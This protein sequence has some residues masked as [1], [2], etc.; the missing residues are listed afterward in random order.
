MKRVTA[1]A[2]LPAALVVGGPAEAGPV[3]C[4]IDAY[5][6]GAQDHVVPFVNC[7]DSTRALADTAHE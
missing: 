1:A 4:S 2:A 6:G 5:T 7:W 3:Y